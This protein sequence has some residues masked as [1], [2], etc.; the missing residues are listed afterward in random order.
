METCHD[1]FL[2]SAYRNLASSLGYLLVEVDLLCVVC[3]CLVKG[4]IRVDTKQ[5]FSL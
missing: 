1:A 5:A 4:R 3:L 2:P